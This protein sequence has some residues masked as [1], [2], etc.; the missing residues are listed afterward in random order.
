[1][2]GHGAWLRG[3][4][5]RQTSELRGAKVDHGGRGR[6]V[7]KESSKKMLKFSEGLSTRE[8]RMLFVASFS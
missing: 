1:M 4:V 5:P 2:R 8:G 6:E 3:G 7:N